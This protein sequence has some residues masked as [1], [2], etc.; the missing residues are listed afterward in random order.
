MDPTVYLQPRDVVVGFG[1]LKVLAPELES[2]QA[3][4]ALHRSLASFATTGNDGNRYVSLSAA[5]AALEM[6]EEQCQLL[7]YTLAAVGGKAGTAAAA[8]AGGAAVDSGASIFDLS[9]FLMAQLYNREAQKPETQDHWPDPSA[10]TGAQ[11]PADAFKAAGGRAVQPGA[12]TGLLTWLARV[13]ARTCLMGCAGAV[14]ATMQFIL[15]A[16]LA[17]LLYL[18]TAGGLPHVLCIGLIFE[19]DTYGRAAY[20]AFD[21]IQVPQSFSSA[22]SVHNLQSPSIGLPSCVPALGMHSQH[23]RVACRI[24]CTLERLHSRSDQRLGRTCYCSTCD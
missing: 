24:H 8:A 9:L 23:L 12:S 7:L 3:V 13:V 5:A 20:G 2:V 6:P 4:Q 19:V 15:G 16:V 18:H 21:I 14:V 11:Q 1:L 10:N 17:V 22:H